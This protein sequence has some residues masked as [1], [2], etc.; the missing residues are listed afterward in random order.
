METANAL[1]TEE[2]FWRCF[3]DAKI[4]EEYFFLYVHHSNR[5]VFAVNALCLLVS[6][7]GVAAW[8]TDFAHPFLSGIVLLAAQAVSILQPLYPYN[9]RLHASEFI[10]QEYREHNL[11]AEQTLNHYYLGALDEAALSAKLDQFQLDTSRIEKKY[12]GPKTFAQNKRLHKIAEQHTAQYM[13]VHFNSR[14]A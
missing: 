5:R 9:D 12:C 3:I 10:Y 1:S 14:G 6:C 2:S 11:F 7:T 8:L 13:D 4:A